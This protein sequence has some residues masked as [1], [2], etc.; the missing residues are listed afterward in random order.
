MNKY[1][2]S[3]LPFEK[4]E[5]DDYKFSGWLARYGNKDRDGDII[6]KGAFKD[7]IAN[8]DTYKLHYN[9]KRTNGDW[10]TD[11]NLKEELDMVIGTFKAV[12]K[13]EGVWID[14]ELFKDEENAQKVYKLLKSGAISEMS[15]GFGVMDQEDYVYDK[16][17]GGYRFM[18][19]IITEGSVVDVPANPLA[20]IEQVK[21]I[22][23]KFDK[24]RRVL[25]L[26]EEIKALLKKIK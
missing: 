7:A 8:K 3:L 14:A 16:E 19:A 17:I 10:V 13:E 21:S 25:E 26:R 24:E 4:S 15:I 11:G 1:K 23:K 6:E 9:H 2:K 20:T 12:D 18:K 22:D 5:N